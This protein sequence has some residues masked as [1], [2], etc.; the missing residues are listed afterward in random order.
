[1]EQV[2]HVLIDVIHVYRLH[3]VHVRVK[4]LKVPQQEP[5]AVPQLQEMVGHVTRARPRPTNAI[6]QTLLRGTLLMLSLAELR[7][8]APIW[9]SEN[10]FDSATHQRNT[11]AP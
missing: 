3:R 2:Q 11:S 5:Q 8:L 10:T 9:T 6:H 7:T 1:M 4:A